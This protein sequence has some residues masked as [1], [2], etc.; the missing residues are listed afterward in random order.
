MKK[1]NYIRPDKLKKAGL[2]VV[3]IFILSFNSAAQTEGNLTLEMAQDLA[4]KNYPLTKQQNLVQQTASYS[5]MNLNRGYL[6]QLSINGQATYQSD[7]T[8]IP[9]TL[10]NIKITPPDKDQ[11]KITADVT[12]VLY[13]GGVINNQKKIQEI[14]ALAE[15][16]KINIEL[17]KLK[18]RINQIYLGILLLDEQLKQTAII[19]KDLDAGI[20][21]L[22]AQV[23]NGTAY[24]SNLSVLQAESL[25][26]N[27]RKTEL[28]SS[29]NSY[30]QVLGI[31]IKRELPPNSKL[32]IPSVSPVSET[33]VIERNELKWYHFQD[34]LLFVQNKM[35]GIK[36]RPKLQLFGQ[37][38][39]GRPG[40]NQLN[41][42]FDWF[43][44]GGIKLNWSF[45]GLY[46]SNKEKKLN[47][48]TRSTVDIQ[49]ELFVL[50]TNTQI[51][52]Q[53]GDIEKFQTLLKS[54]EEIVKL[55][56]E[57]KKASN[58][59]LENGVIT[60]SDY[61]REVNAS[62]QAK[63]TLIVHK[64]QL[65]QSQLNYQNTLGK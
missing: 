7:V 51:K 52:Q 3:Y 42:E 25:K 12:Q 43:Y 62:D 59:Q 21:R 16:E 32:E 61:I 5:L 2:L 46:T 26:N 18:E 55:R 22:Q 27:Q 1:Y 28:E 13:D 35:I 50:N 6:P 54:D 49:K 17:Q 65:L 30:L 23:K 53:Q 20:N 34:S 44:I 29:R 14:N 19:Q 10:P 63:Q 56:E 4:L 40:L 24:R 38:G 48:I 47:M 11:Y 41:N 57:I 60:S 31:F 9:I 37:G 15:E 39:Y 36:N 8:Q 45:G 64:L 33:P 58:V